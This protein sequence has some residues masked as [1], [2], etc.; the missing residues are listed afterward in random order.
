MD[1]RETFPDLITLKGKTAVI[2][3]GASGIGLENSKLL[4]KAGASLALFDLDSEQG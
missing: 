2:T 4:G 3:G 1:M